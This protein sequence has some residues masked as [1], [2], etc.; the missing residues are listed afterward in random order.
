MRASEM[1]NK[2]AWLI[3]R[4]N[5]AAGFYCNVED[6]IVFISRCPSDTIIDE[7]AASFLIENDE[8]KNVVSFELHVNRNYSSLSKWIELEIYSVVEQY[9]LLDSFKISNK[10][11]PQGGI[12]QKSQTIKIN[13]DAD[14]KKIYVHTDFVFKKVVIKVK[15]KFIPDCTPTLGDRIGLSIPSS[16]F[17]SLL[18]IFRLG[19]KKKSIEIISAA[20][21]YIKHPHNKKTL[22]TFAPVNFPVYKYNTLHMFDGLQ[23]DK[24]FIN[25]LSNNWYR[26]GVQ[27]FSENING[28]VNILKD[29]ILNK[30]SCELIT[31]GTSMGAYG[32]VLFGILLKAHKIIAINP[33]LNLFVKASRS[34]SF[35]GKHFHP[36]PHLVEG[37]KLYNGKAYLAFSMNDVIDS[38]NSRII[39]KNEIKSV[40]LI[41]LN[42]AHNVGDV[43]NTSYFWIYEA[44]E[45][46]SLNNKFPE[47][48]LR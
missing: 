26:D 9:Q 43:L 11:L 42:C 25:D 12:I 41:K 8:Q 30:P 45:F 27:N 40:Q 7:L 17:N 19:S 6:D 20:I 32:A 1:Y 13:L 4:A 14:S 47:Y 3:R 33:E 44:M 15:I 37:L 18:D 24:I 34:F 46:N 38:E 22:I 28:T 5:N 21:R 2:Q 16:T 35:M 10:E 48:F 39:E 23:Y 29:I 31:F 36:Y